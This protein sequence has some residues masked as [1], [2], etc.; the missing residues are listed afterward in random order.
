MTHNDKSLCVRCTHMRPALDPNIQKAYLGKCLKREWPFTLAITLE[1]WTEC[2]VFEDSGKTYVPPDPAAA[3][4]AATAAAKGPKRVEFYYSSKQKSGEL[5]PCDNAKALA[6]VKELQAHGVDAKAVDVAG[7]ADRFP[8]YH[9]SVSG[10]DASVRPVFGAKGALVDDFGTTVPALLVFE[11]DRYPTMAFPRTDAKRGTI[12][13][14]QALEDLIAEAQ[15]S[16]VVAH[17]H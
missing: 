9:K 3:T 17:A 8:I 2:N 12:R 14:E 13:V 5:F 16:V 6:L 15:P 11:G 4:V 7:V 10:P 1:G